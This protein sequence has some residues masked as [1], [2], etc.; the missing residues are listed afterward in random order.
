MALTTVSA[1]NSLRLPLPVVQP[2]LRLPTQGRNE[3]QRVVVGVAARADAQFAVQIQPFKRL[4]FGR[5]RR[6]GNGG[7]ADVAVHL[8]AFSAHGHWRDALFEMPDDVIG[9]TEGAAVDAHLQSRAHA[10]F[11]GRVQCQ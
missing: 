10:P 3:R 6:V 9:K 1:Q 4:P 8:H 2:D 11:H 7:A 5:C